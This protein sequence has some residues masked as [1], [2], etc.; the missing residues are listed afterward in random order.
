MMSIANALSALNKAAS[1]AGILPVACSHL[2]TATGG[3]VVHNLSIPE[4]LDL[5][6]FDLESVHFECHCDAVPDQWNSAAS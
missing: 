6:S 5:A 4:I 3:D 2:R 1:V